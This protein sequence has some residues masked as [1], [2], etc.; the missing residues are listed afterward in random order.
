LRAGAMAGL[1]LIG[2][3]AARLGSLIQYIPHPVTTGFTTG[4]AVVI[5][6]IQ[7]KDVFGLRI[8]GSPESY[9]DRWKLMWTARGSVSGWEIL[10]AAFTLGLL[11]LLPR[12][13]K[14]V[15][16]PLIAL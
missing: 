2:M 4:I 15:P 12:V 14:R 11:F 8:A 6:T 10:I 9:L 16:A 5:A 1:M 3:G 13:I 7:L